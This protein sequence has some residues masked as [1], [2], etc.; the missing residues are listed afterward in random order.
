MIKPGKYDWS[1][2]KLQSN[3]TNK[4]TW[5]NSNN[6]EADNHRPIKAIPVNQISIRS[7][8]NASKPRRCAMEIVAMPKKML[9]QK[10]QVCAQALAFTL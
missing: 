6:V 3:Q 9:P 1:Y 4:R 2:K 10:P 7:G 8:I 5:L